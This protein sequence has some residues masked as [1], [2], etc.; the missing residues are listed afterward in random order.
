[1]VDQV[2]RK[3]IDKLEGIINDKNGQPFLRLVNQ[4]TAAQLDAIGR[5]VTVFFHPRRGKDSIR[6]KSKQDKGVRYFTGQTK[7]K[8]L[9]FIS[10]KEYPDLQSL[11]QDLDNFWE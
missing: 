11:E 2:L 7:T 1:M 3:R 4:N 9:L 10:V 6:K 5:D 8:K